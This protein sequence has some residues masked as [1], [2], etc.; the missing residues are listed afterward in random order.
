VDSAIGWQ[1]LEALVGEVDAMLADTREDNLSEVCPSVPT[2]PLPIAYTLQTGHADLKLA[3]NLANV[4][5]LLLCS[6]G[7]SV[8][9]TTTRRRSSSPLRILSLPGKDTTANPYI[10][11][12]CEALEHAGMSTINIH[13][14]DGKRF[15]FDI[16]HIHW[17]EFYVTE[18]PIHIAL[19]SAPA[20]I[21]YILITKLL[22]KK[23]AWTVH[24]VIPIKARNPR[25]L[26][27]YLFCVRLLI[28]AYVFMNLSSEAEFVK[29]FPRAKTKILWRVPHTPYPVSA[30]SP[31]RRAELRERLSGG[32][33]CLLAGFLGD[34]RPYKNPMALA[35]LPQHDTSGREIKL[36]LAGAVDATYNVV[37]IEDSLSGIPLDRLVRIPRRLSDQCLAELIQAVDFVFLPYLRGSNSGFSMLVLSCGQRLLCSA[38]P[39]FGDLMNNLGS[40]WIY[41]FDHQATD[42][43]E[44][45][46]AAL[47]RLQ[48]EVVDDNAKL[49]LR[50]FLDGC[51]FDH[52]A[53]QFH[54]L[55]RQLVE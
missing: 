23:I 34:I 22:R 17:P 39:M 19:V 28:D 14:F 4:G 27:F 9:I 47:S 31:Q 15:N 1:R 24:D 48:H 13:T 10:T 42:L 44:E 12:F 55:Y 29:R 49:R 50:G 26:R 7:G 8:K 51:S 33:N 43:S 2:G 32:S 36:I 5:L 16:L 41:V 40:P 30:I 54:L 38:L 18:R 37:E 6:S 53:Q 52:G 21:F 35:Y 11:H 46:R 25:L 45:L 3:G 20:I